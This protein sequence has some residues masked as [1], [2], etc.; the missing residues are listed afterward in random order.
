MS[1]SVTVCIPVFNGARYVRE[2]VDSA[3]AQDYPE[4]SVLVCDNSSTDGTLDELAGIVDPRLGI[5]CHTE[6]VGMAANWNRA[7]SLARGDLILMLSADDCLLPGAIRGLVAP[8]LG[9]SP[10]DLCFGKAA[11]LAE[12]GQRAAGEAAGA[13]TA[14]RI[15]DLEAFVV[16]R[17]LSININATMFRRECLDFREDVGVVCDL[18]L[19]IRLG[20]EGRV[21]EGIAEPVVRYREHQGALSANRERMWSETLAVYSSHSRDNPRLAMYLRRIH[22]TLLWLCAY[23]G[24]SG[25]G[26]QAAGYIECYGRHLGVPGRALL[27]L[28]ARLPFSLDL[29]LKARKSLA[30]RP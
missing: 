13:S 10:P 4:L 29:L 22:L 2:A 16:A 15:E 14:G 19:F 17:A 1:P 7:A 5:H 11:W 30:A 21:A 25:S 18:D 26:A 28:V 20:K 8:F 24:K 23:L 6:H 12:S 9:P 27:R 3:L